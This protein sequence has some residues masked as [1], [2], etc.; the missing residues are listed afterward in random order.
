[1][2]IIAVGLRLATR[3]PSLGDDLCEAL[4]QQEFIVHYQPVIDL[5]ENRCTGAEALIR[6]RHPQRGIVAPD[7]FIALAEETATIVPMT[8]W[9]MRRVGEELGEF[10][11]TN[12]DLHIA[13][14]LAPAHF[15]DLEIVADTKAAAAEFDVQPSQLGFEV[16]ERSLINETFCREVI[17]GLCDFGSQVTIEDFGTGY[18]NLSYIGMFRIHFLKIDKAF[19]KTIGSSAATSGLAQIIID[20]GRALGL[21]IIAEGVETW[22][23]I[24]YLREQGVH[25]AQG[26]YFSRPLP[27]PEFIAFVQHFETKSRR[28]MEDRTMYPDFEATRAQDRR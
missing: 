26:W 14:N 17:E 12:V 9:L 15:L 6:W 16:S 21:K 1:L 5:Q 27:A 3:R 22:E 10:L 20:M 28:M 19:V 11:R 7:V 24:H 18:A 4:D 2:I 23:Q 25:L 13:I 8:R